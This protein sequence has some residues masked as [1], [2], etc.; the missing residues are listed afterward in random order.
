MD[1]STFLEYVGEGG[2]GNR[3]ETFNPEGDSAAHGPRDSI[4]SE[5][6]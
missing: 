3:Q 5:A 2:V 4:S 1:T 6:H